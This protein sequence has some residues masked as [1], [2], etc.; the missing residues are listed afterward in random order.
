MP[1]EA[2][3]FREAGQGAGLV[4]LHSNAASSSQ[5]RALMDRLSPRWHVLAADSY[6]AGKSPPWPDDRSVTLDDEAA[7]LEPVFT[8]AGTPFTLL[9]H[10]YGGA[11]ALMTALRQ[12]QRVRALVLYEPTLFALLRHVAAPRGAGD[13][14]EAAVDASL[15]HLAAGRQDAA[16]ASF[17]DYWMGP[18]AYA[19]M[20]EARRAPIAAAVVNVGGWARALTTEPT[21]P[22]AFATLRLPT[23]LM[24]GER[25]PASSRGVAQVLA[26]LLPDLRVVELPGLGHMGPVTHADVVNAEIER[27]LDRLPTPESA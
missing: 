12:P 16:A 25:S 18:G 26:Q 21:P 13:G 1:T 22:E 17:I 2:P 4:C 11:I 24:V 15:V 23:L 20:P 27:F 9:G 7:L 6:G 10:S 8:R 19:A 3:F 14:I 5:W